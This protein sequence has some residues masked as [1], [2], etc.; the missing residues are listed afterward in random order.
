MLGI[1]GS[2]FDPAQGSTRPVYVHEACHALM[3]RLFGIASQGGWLH[4]GLANYYQLRW[5]KQDTRAMARNLIAKRRV[6]PLQNLLNGRPIGIENYA[7]SALFIE[8]IMVE[9]TR[10][11]RLLPCIRFLANR[12]S[13]AFEPAS[14]IHFGAG[15]ERVQNAWIAWLKAR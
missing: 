9:S 11:A 13:T 10:K 6:V 3:A 4:E 14:K 1:A 12:G 7:Q 8:W 5:V 15:V 2:Y